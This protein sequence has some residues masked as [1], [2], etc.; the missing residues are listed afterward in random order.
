MPAKVGDELTRITLDDVARAAGVSRTTASES[1]NGK[2]R[3][4]AATREA[5]RAAA[6][7]LG[8][9]ADPLARR[10]AS[11]RCDSLIGLFALHLDLD[12]V[13]RKIQALQ[14]LLSEQGYIAPIYAYGISVDEEVVDHELLL[15]NLRRQ[16]PRAI[17]CST[18]GLHD[19][20][21]NELRYFQ[22]E[23]GT[24]VCYDA[25][26]DLAC[27]AVLF[28]REHNT[29]LA[30]R[31]LLELGHRRLGFYGNSRRPLP[32]KRRYPDRFVGFKKA[33]REFGL[34]VTPEW[35][36]TGDDCEAAGA[37]LAEQYLSLPEQP[38]GMC[39]V[40]DHIAAA[41]ITQM[42]RHG[43]RV[44][45]DVSVVGHDNTPVACFGS[46]VPITTVSQPVETIA[47]NV[48]RL[49]STRMADTAPCA[50]RTVHV[51]GELILRESTA[52]PNVT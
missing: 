47:E 34:E 6:E 22:E 4:A 26:I 3:V 50:P 48:V 9:Q 16:R 52:P 5:V 25:P 15:R 8:F 2:G 32:G 10:L 46:I 19:K 37:R 7:R 12:V 41:F 39:I 17:V 13:S 45:E 35:M 40:N 11:G 28:D 29:Y 38:T 49:L 51:Q 1:L 23:G 27:D 42:Y 20:T 33:L 21:L 14:R 31:H 44:P 18:W 43:L 30:A 36:F 24:L